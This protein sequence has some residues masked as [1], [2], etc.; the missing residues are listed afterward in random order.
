MPAQGNALGCQPKNPHALS[1]FFSH[2]L[3]NL[4]TFVFVMLT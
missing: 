4:V 2:A 1:P 3:H